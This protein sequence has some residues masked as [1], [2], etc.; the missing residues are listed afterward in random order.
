[1]F[2]KDEDQKFVKDRLSAMTQKVKIIHFTQSIECSYCRESRQLL[3]EL[4]LLSDKLSLEVVNFQID[5]DVVAKY[6]IDKIPATILIP[7]DESNPGIRFFGIPSGYEFQSL[8]E[9][10]IDVSSCNHGFSDDVLREIQ[11]I[12][13]TVH[14]QVFV[15]PTCPYCPAAVRTAHRLALANKH[16]TADMVEATEFPHLAQKYAVSGVPKS[17]INETSSLEGAVPEQMFIDKI[18]DVIKN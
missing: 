10:I 9:D 16:I 1:M 12:D 4:I 6:N 14:I 17:I 18:N 11:A 13:K 15:T 5:K 7:E 8:L 2:L 3:E